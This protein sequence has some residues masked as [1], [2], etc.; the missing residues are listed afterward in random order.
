MTFEKKILDRDALSHEVSRRRASGQK[1]VFTNGCF[2]MLHVGHVRYLAAAKQQGEY[3]VVALNSDES[4]ARLKGP[5][6]PILPAD[7]RARLIAGCVA[8]DLVTV[9]EEDT[10]IPLLRL[11]RP[12]ILIKGA[13]Y[14]VDGVVGRE[15]VWEYGGEVRTL[16]LTEGASSSNLIERILEINSV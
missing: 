6:R 12:E 1:M 2:D 4:I 10:P 8:V 16:E 14:G 11:L 3:L 9:F 5:G 7:Q 13:D 15:V